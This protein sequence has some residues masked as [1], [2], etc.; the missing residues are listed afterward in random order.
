METPRTHKPCVA[1]SFDQ[2]F[3]RNSSKSRMFLL[4]IN[5]Y[6]QKNVLCCFVCYLI[7]QKQYKFGWD[8]NLK[9]RSV[10]DLEME[11]LASVLIWV[12]TD[13]CMD[14]IRI[15]SG[16]RQDL[17]L[18]QISGLDQTHRTFWFGF[19]VNMYSIYL[20]L[21]ISRPFERPYKK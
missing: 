1:L 17:V 5:K 9:T 7:V 10:S 4:K 15:W 14:H 12:L 2:L 19:D 20:L 18:V 3:I 11:Y 6:A 13:I 21:F 8:I 16:S